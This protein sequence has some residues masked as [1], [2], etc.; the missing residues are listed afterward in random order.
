MSINAGQLVKSYSDWLTEKTIF[1]T[2]GDNCRIT[3]PYLDRHNDKLEIYIVDDKMGGMEITDDGLIINDLLLCGI[4]VLSPAR[5]NIVDAI[6]CRF[7]VTITGEEISVNSTIQEFPRK[8]HRLIQAML[9]INDMFMTSRS[10]VTNLF[11]DEIK[12]YFD[13]HDVRYSSDVVFT[14]KGGFIHNFDYLIPKSKSKPER[15]IKAINNPDKNSI[16][17]L[18]FAWGDIKDDR[19]KDAISYA[20]LNDAE[21]KV[22]SEA[23]SSLINYSVVPILWSMRDAVI[24]ELAA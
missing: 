22:S 16:S 7:G 15:I 23:L 13:A 11:A 17:Q 8:K 20:I 9:A 24:K 4:N 12:A 19:P 3:T 14:G 2:I 10:H 5:K 21:K 6:A 1:S 18:L